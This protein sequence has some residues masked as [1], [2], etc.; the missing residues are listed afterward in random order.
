LEAEGYDIRSRTHDGEL[1]EQ[2]ARTGS[3]DLV[4]LDV[5]LPK[6]DGFTVLHDLRKNSI[7]DTYRLLTARSTTED[8]VGGL[9]EGAD[10]YLT[11]PFS[12]EELL[13]RIRSV[14]RRTGRSRRSFIF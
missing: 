2:L 6:K 4:L 14:V 5:L 12:F 11:K 7:S 13:A 1:G 8:I 9:D 10:D 3:F